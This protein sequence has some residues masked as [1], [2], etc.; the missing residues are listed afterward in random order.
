MLRN[1]LN[2][3]TRKQ[4]SPD[5]VPE[6]ER[7]T[8]LKMGLTIT[9]VLAG[10]TVLSAVSSADKLYAS[11]SDYKEGYPYKPHYTMV[12]R[13]NLCVDCERCVEACTTTNQVP[14][15]GYRTR[16]YEKSMPEAVGRKRE[17]IPLLCNHCN[18]PPCVRGCPTRATYKDE[19]NGI[20]MMDTK[21]C[22]GCKTC[23][24]ACP[25]NARYYNDEK[26]AVDKCN[27][28]FDTRLSKGEKLTACA[29]AC[30]TGARTFGDLS[31]PN[32]T[33]YQL[34]HQ[35][36]RRV[37]VLR[38]ETGVEPNVFYMKA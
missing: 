32:S 10:G 6:P 3:D 29:N 33:V 8:F 14:D 30:P 36:E 22:V 13:T 17:F 16:V 7:R 20:V 38:P 23:M 37:W 15:Y 18:N 25:Y 19:Q 28:C 21:K 24:V 2:L 35:L 11:A 4:E 26:R 9:G 34:V 12:I 5:T 1:N 27:F 31:D